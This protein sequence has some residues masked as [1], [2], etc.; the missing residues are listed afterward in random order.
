MKRVF[1]I[2]VLIGLIGGGI[3]GLLQI[4]P[5]GKTRQGAEIRV[6]TAQVRDLEST[7]PATGEV[8]PLLN[9]IV[10]S[11][12]S[13]R[14]TQIKVK[15][16]DSVERGQVLMELDRT[17]LLT[18]VR[19]SERS[20]Q[21]DQLRLEKSER[22]YNRL[23]ELYTKKFVGEQEYLDAETDF[24]LAQL[25]LEIAQARLDDAE[26]DLSKTTITAPHEGIVT[27]LDVVDG[28]VISGATSVSNGT[29]LLTIAQ[30]NELFMEAN[31]NEIDV[32]K[33]YVGQTARLSFDAIQ[34]FEVEGTINVIAPSARKDENVRA[35]PIEVVFEV[36]D[37]RVRPGISATLEV[38]VEAVENA[39]SVLI[40]GIFNEGDA[41]VAF[42]KKGEG[43]DRR[44]V[45]VGINNL[46]YI[47]IKAGIEVGEEVALSRPPEFRRTND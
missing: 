41:R 10:K 25:N 15:E 13:G 44:E 34:D 32:E 22:N 26:E 43:W 46:Q 33:L 21:A 7:V 9:S 38:P 36:E 47:E 16:G 45:E 24:N 31:I 5:D 27:L 39:V 37:S 35:F 40:S 30:L 28:Q 11:E 23:K 4:L 17:S 20:F 6:D 1:V 19:E 18:G 2:L 42:V 3:Y 12:I 29:D 8:L 14:I